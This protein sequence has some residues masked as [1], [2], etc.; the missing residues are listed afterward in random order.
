MIEL[1]RKS[2][3]GI[4]KF[5]GKFVVENNYDVIISGLGTAGSMAAITAAK[6]GLR[7]LGIE[8]ENCMGGQSTAGEVFIYYLGARGGL[9]ERIDQMAKEMEEEG[10]VTTNEPYTD[11]GVNPETKKYILEKEAVKAGVEIHYEAT[12]IGIFAED[13]VVKG[14]QW[15]HQNE[16]HNAFA[17]IVIDATADGY[18]CEM[19]GC[20]MRLGRESDHQCQPYSSVMVTMND[21]KINCRYSDCGY[22]DQYNEKDI[23]KK[24]INSNTYPLH[25]RSKYTKE[26]EILSFSRMLGCREGKRIVGEGT[27][28]IKKLLSGEKVSKP[29]FCGYA[30]IDVHGK[31]MAFESREFQYWNVVC[32]LWGI[33]LRIPV[34]ADV[35]FPKGY[36]GILA[37]GR[38]LSVDHDVASALR[39]KRDMHKCGEAI[40][41][42]AFEMVKEKCSAKDVS[43]EEMLPMLE[44]NQCLSK[45]TS[46]NQGCFFDESGKEL[47]FL[48]NI[49]SIKSELSGKKPGWAIW[50]AI[51]M[52]DDVIIPHL[53]QWIRETNIDLIR[54][55]AL[56]LGAKGHRNAIDI[57][58]E[59]VEETDLT[60]FKNSS[61]YNQPR[62]IA[63]IFLLGELADYE[64]IPLLIQILDQEKKYREFEID[65]NEFIENHGDFYFQ[66]YTYALMALIRI[67]ECHEEERKDIKRQ[68]EVRLCRE[69]FHLYLN[70]K[71]GENLRHDM[72][73]RVKKI[74]EK[75][76][77]NWK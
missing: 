44:E 70:L 56:V 72:G 13:N 77:Q 8:T 76:T 39:M 48:E 58:K 30:N 24:I 65:F 7:V 43:Y 75:Y 55:S 46:E 23:S 18:L 54:N 26:D 45:N 28:S 3:N 60:C 50:S 25:N 2:E 6:K 36:Q 38:H 40:G 66:L 49:S 37:A 59:M 61:M 19:L 47:I 64:S 9:Y 62:V 42:L 12:V 69:D 35:C 4:K 32:G 71:D 41:I 20:E 31:D 73:K 33:R 21:N 67:G 52:E 51:R 34:P 22:I 1:Y 53:N 5:Q 57:L 63:A 16:V 29:L 14:V 68:L 15:V 74:V 17:K 27:L 10:F 11:N